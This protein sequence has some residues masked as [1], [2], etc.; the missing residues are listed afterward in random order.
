MWVL[1][2]CRVLGQEERLT[3]FH[4]LSAWLRFGDEVMDA[5][6]QG[7]ELIDQLDQLQ[8]NIR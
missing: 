1:Q 2:A 6:P 4:G 8:A 5:L 7:G 3:L